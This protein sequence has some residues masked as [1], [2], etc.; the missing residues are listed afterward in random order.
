LK[1]DKSIIIFPF[2]NLLRFIAAM[3]VVFHHFAIQVPP[4]NDGVLNQWIGNG[5]FMV[6]LFFV[7]SGFVLF[8]RYKTYQ[9]ESSK[10]VFQF[11]KKRAI[12]LLPL[13]FVGLIA[14]LCYYLF[15]TNQVD[16]VRVVLAFTGL[17][18][19]DV[20]SFPVINVPSW[21]LSVEFFLY[22]MFPFVFRLIKNKNRLVV[23]KWSIGFWLLMEVLYFFLHREIADLH[24]D[25]LPIFSLPSFMMGV[26]AYLFFPYVDRYSILKKQLLVAGSSIL[27]V[28]LLYLP[29][30]YKNYSGLLAPL[31]GLL[32]LSLAVMRSKKSERKKVTDF[33]GDLSYP[34][35]ILHW[36]IYEVYGVVLEY[37]GVLSRHTLVAF[38]TYILIVIL[39]S[40]VANFVEGKLIKK[41]KRPLP[42]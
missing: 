4:F 6:N 20:W 13:Y 36:P 12:R 28:I 29:F 32:I 39:I 40:I 42:L 41:T 30:F 37:F 17:Q 18:S 24:L 31:F 11:Y 26:V 15:V 34:I 14:S 7:L 38:G 3:I 2:L 21:S 27:V 16:V 10:E 19:F 22:L 23:I 9:F 35:Y 5:N 1:K 8:H 33:L 25:F